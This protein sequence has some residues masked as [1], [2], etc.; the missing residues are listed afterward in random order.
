MANRYEDRAEAV[1]FALERHGNPVIPMLVPAAPNGDGP[2]T[3]V[4][5]GEQT[6]VMPTGKAGFEAFLAV[7]AGVDVEAKLAALGGV[8]T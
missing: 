2:A 4:L 6:W 7:V 5:Y 8:R 3:P 1:E